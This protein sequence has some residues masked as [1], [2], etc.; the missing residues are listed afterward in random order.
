M[1]R[2]K[3]M[4][5]RF[6]DE[7]VQFFNYLMAERPMFHFIVALVLFG[8]AVERWILPFSNWVPLIV[9]VWATIQYGSYQRQVLVEDL[10]R[11]W[12]QFTLNKSPMTAIEH[13]EWLNKLLMEVWSEF[14]NPKLSLRFLSI[15]EKRLKH[16]RP[17]LIEKIELQEF[18]FGSNPPILGL[19]GTRW[20]TSGDQC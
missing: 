14:I 13:C 12:K 20:A 19:H 9:T 4:R 5:D 15:V 1:A 11:N 8:W 16:R 18:S 6:V 17:R 3:K 10:K 2:K 7:F